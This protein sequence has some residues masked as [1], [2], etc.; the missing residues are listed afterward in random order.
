MGIWLSWFGENWK[1]HKTFSGANYPVKAPIPSCIC[2][3]INTGDI[4]VP[5]TWFSVV[6]EA[7]NTKP[8]IIP[9][10]YSVL[11]E[12]LHNPGRSCWMTMPKLANEN[13]RK[14]NIPLN[15]LAEL[16]NPL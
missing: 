9:G 5:Q 14:P 3:H 12:V 13:A 11:P 10:Y 7:S 6:I 15:S 16:N 4:V 2:C 1:R 8:P